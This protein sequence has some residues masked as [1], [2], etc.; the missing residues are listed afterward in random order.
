MKLKQNNIEKI[1]FDL[2]GV[3]TSEAIY[4]YSAALTTYELVY[5]REYYGYQDIDREWCYKNIDIIYD[6]VFCGGKTIS[7]VKNLGVNTNWDLAYMVFCASEYLQPEPD[8]FSQQHFESVCMFIENMQIKPPQ[9]YDGMEGLLETILPPKTK[10]DYKRGKGKLWQEILTSFDGWYQGIKEL[11]TPLLPIEDIKEVLTKL[12]VKGYS[13]G[14]GTGRPKAEAE[15]PLKKWGIYHLFDQNLSAFYDDVKFAEE[16]LKPDVP[17]AKP[18]PFVFLKAGFGSKM[19][20]ADLLKKGIP[21]GETEKC[22]VVGDA[23]S[24]LLAAK[25]G[26]MKFCAVLT[27]INGEKAR[28]VFEE[29]KADMI[30]NSILDLGDKDED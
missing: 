18:H 21:T 11:E 20:N 25:I 5:S 15:Y 16:E 26:C 8:S 10:G 29:N 14:I 7:A 17:L 9:L 2:D 3:I 1:I 12:K 22:L 23:M 4:W 28:P 30:L 24:D 6:T 13:L 27:G 19:S